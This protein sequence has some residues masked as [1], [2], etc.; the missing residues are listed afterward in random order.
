MEV[1]FSPKDVSPL[2]QTLSVKLNLAKNYLITSHFLD[3]W[4]NQSNLITLEQCDSLIFFEEEIKNALKLFPDG[5]NF[6]Y[7][8]KDD[9]RG[10]IFK[11]SLEGDNYFGIDENLNTIEFSSQDV[12]REIYP[13]LNPLQINEDEEKIFNIEVNTFSYPQNQKVN[14]YLISIQRRYFTY[15]TQKEIILTPKNLCD[16]NFILQQTLFA[17][18][19]Q[20]SLFDDLFEESPVL[21]FMREQIIGDNIDYS[22]LTFPQPKKSDLLFPLI[23]IKYSSHYSDG[24]KVN[25]FYLIIDSKLELTEFNLLDI[26]P[27][28]GVMLSNYKAFMEIVKNSKK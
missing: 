8:E 7:F 27:K 24:K 23:K 2:P 20:K 19:V 13:L 18:K 10:V 28:I 4:C 26:P 6:L 17:N 22:L 16:L 9:Q 21:I 25:E 3:K 12:P 1:K 14:E 11:N 15:T 5:I